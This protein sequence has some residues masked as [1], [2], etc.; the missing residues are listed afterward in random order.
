MSADPHAS[1]RIASAGDNL[2]SARAA[3]ILLHGR[4]G[5]SSDMLGLAGYLSLPGIAF[6]APEA[7]GNS[8]YPQ[9]FIAPAVQNQ[10]WLDS[11][12]AAV[13]RA[14]ESL[15]AAGIPAERLLIAGFS[16]GACLALE[17][18]AR[19][20]RRYGAV[21]ALSG[22]LIGQ[23]GTREG[24]Y[25]GDLA[26]T[27]VLLGCSDTDFHIPLASVQESARTMRQLGAAVDERIYPDMGHE[28]NEDEM[29]WLRARLG[30]LAAVGI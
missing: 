2:E 27:P 29:A 25:S 14:I 28:V 17:F 16:Q 19:H 4:G 12:L 6:I 21:A 15:A 8:W 3:A 23:P 20:P 18:A 26:G 5:S 9:R 13:G 11:A 10:P 30:E 1:A 22:G 7:A 24:S